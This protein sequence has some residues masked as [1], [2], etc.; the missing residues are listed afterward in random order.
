M[1]RFTDGVPSGRIAEIEA[2]LSI[3][4]IREIPHLRVRHYALP[5][6]LMVAEALQALSTLPE[7]QSAEPNSLFP[8]QGLPTDPSFGSQWALHNVGQ[9]APHRDNALARLGCL[10]RA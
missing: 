6:S 4:L 8:I 7:V 2:A 9:T 3:D 10:L 5:E 1:V